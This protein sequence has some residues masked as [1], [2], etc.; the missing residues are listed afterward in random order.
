MSINLLLKAALIWLLIACL[1][2]GNGIVRES[3]FAPQFGM[4]VALPLSGITLSVIIFVVTYVAFSFL[5]ATSQSACIAVGVQWVIMTLAFEFLFGHYVAGKS[6]VDLL[7]VFNLASG[8][9]ML[10]V[11]LVSLLSPCFVARIKG[12]R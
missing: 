1:A 12:I 9:L 7:Q 5:A 8:D 4:A 6:W 10:L 11:L 2:I 3:L